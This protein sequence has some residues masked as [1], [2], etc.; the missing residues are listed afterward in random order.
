VEANKVLAVTGNTGMIWGLANNASTYNTTVNNVIS[1]KT[2]GAVGYGLYSNQGN[3]INF[4][5]NSVY[6]ASSAAGA[7]VAAY[8]SHT[9][10]T[11]GNVK[12]R[13]NI[14]SNEGG[15]VA[16]EIVFSDFI[17][18]D[19]NTYYTTGTVLI[20]RSGTS[21]DY[22]NLTDWMAASDLDIS[23]I[24]HKPAFANTTT[25]EPELTN[26]DVWAIHGRGVQIPG[27]DHDGSLRIPAN[28][29]TYRTTGHS[30][31][32]GSGYYPAVPL[33]L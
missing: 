26:P 12:L 20:S 13:N 10:A 21:D 29:T 16:A 24:V 6:N 14:F 31:S 5:N 17:N 27:N 9:N 2:T 11:E 30:C 1:V 15:G 28:G 33:W 25:L 22:D 32:S 8:F 19:Y 18:S 3:N 4:Y 23:S 7:N